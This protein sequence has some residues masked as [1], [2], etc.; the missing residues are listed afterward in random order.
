MVLVLRGA[1]AVSMSRRSKAYGSPAFVLGAG[2]MNANAD[3]AVQPLGELTLQATRATGA[4]SATT[5]AHATIDELRQLGISPTAEVGPLTDDLIIARYSRTA[6]GGGGDS[7]TFT[8]PEDETIEILASS[9]Y[10]ATSGVTVRHGVDVASSSYVAFPE[11]KVS[12]GWTASNSGIGLKDEAVAAAVWSS[13]FPPQR[14]VLSPGAKWT[15]TFTNAT[16][17]DSLLAGILA[18]RRK[19]IR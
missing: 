15:V 18:R 16:A 10:D 1:G 14:V 5:Y 12:S 8:C 6:V 17:G 3:A 19:L 9:G 2:G 4:R 11:G 7:I 13:Y